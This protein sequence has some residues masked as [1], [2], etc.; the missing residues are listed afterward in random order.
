MTKD[1][2]PAIKPVKLIEGTTDIKAAIGSIQRRG[3][4]FDRD[5][6]AAAIS[7]LA[8]H[9]KHGDTTLI[10]RL[11]EAMPKGARLNALLGY[12]DYFGL[13]RYD[14]DNKVFVHVKNVNRAFDADA[15]QSVLWTSFRPEKAYV[16]IADA[17]DAISKLVARFEKDVEKMGD[18]SVV[19]PAMLAKLK[20]LTVTE[21]AH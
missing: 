6:Q 12:L 5:V 7:V 1:N 3:V 15:A 4:K 21:P 13:A 17:T 10:N 9:A 16:P 18:A 19:D 14:V 20:A 2:A 11:V 8:H